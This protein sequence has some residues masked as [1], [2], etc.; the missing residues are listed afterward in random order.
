MFGHHKGNGGGWAVWQVRVS[1]KH[2]ARIERHREN[3]LQ[4]APEEEMLNLERSITAAA[5]SGCVGWVCRRSA[6]RA[7]RFGERAR[8]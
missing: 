2:V 5:Q 1:D 7:A 6:L 8:L 4:A 3:Q